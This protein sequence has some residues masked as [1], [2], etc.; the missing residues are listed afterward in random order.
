M[1]AAMIFVGGLSEL[2]VAWLDGTVETTPAEIAE[3]ATRAF[4]RLAHR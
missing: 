2:V 3:A 1:L 4:T